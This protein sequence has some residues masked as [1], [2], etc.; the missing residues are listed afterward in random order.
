MSLKEESDELKHI[1]QP[2]PKK[3]PSGYYTDSSGYT[4][5][6]FLVLGILS[7]TESLEHDIFTSYNKIILFHS[8]TIIFF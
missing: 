2:R 1:T 7:F 8:L 6:L 3:F 4:N 5:Q